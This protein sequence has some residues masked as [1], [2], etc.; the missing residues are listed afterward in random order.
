[1]LFWAVGIG[2]SGRIYYTVRVEGFRTIQ[3]SISVEGLSGFVAWAV[4]L[5]VS[6]RRF[7][8][9]K[10]LRRLRALVIRVES[11]GPMVK[12]PKST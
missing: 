8:E 5:R 10:G 11:F 4:G 7:L 1:M 3:I 9:L 12:D 6:R 2:V